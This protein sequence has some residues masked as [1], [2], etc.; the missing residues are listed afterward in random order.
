MNIEDKPQFFKLIANVYAFYRQDF[1]EFA[2][3]V[4]WQ[5]MQPFDFPAVA[6]ALNRHCINPD[7]GQFMPKPADAVRMLKGSSLDSAMIAWSSVDKGIREVGTYESV[8]FHDALIHRVI[9]DM[10]GWIALGTKTEDEWPFVAKEFQNR[11]KG[12]SSRNERPEYPKKLLGMAEAQNAQLG[13]RTMPPRLIG[14]P[15]Q[16]RLVFQQGA[17]PDTRPILRLEDVAAVA[18][19]QLIDNVSTGSKAA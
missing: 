1:S 8:V 18:T 5:A 11:Y 16:A 12:Y 17:A 7:S 10:G 15:E 2:G 6:D 3:N 14:D 9:A 4:W 13:F 19:A